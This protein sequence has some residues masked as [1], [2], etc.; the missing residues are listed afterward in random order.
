MLIACRGE[1]IN[2]S[3]S[4]S[5]FHL[6]IVFFKIGCYQCACI[7][8]HIYAA[9]V[10]VAAIQQGYSVSVIIKTVVAEFVLHPKQNEHC[11]CHPYRKAGDVD[12]GKALV[13]PEVA[14]SYL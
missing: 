8:P 10:H 5:I 2:S 12:G 14:N 11:G 7:G 4:D 6:G 1:E 3:E 13:P 9:I